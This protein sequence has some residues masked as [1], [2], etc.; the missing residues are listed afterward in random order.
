MSVIYF[1][2]LQAVLCGCLLGPLMFMLGA[3]AVWLTKKEVSK[4]ISWKTVNPIVLVY[5]P[6]VGLSFPVIAVMLVI[7]GLDE[8][9]AVMHPTTVAEAIAEH[10]A[11]SA[12]EHH[13]HP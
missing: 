11:Q 3:W 13:F 8:F 7:G 4:N 6:L 2:R 12:I 5:G 1:D 10:D 9:I